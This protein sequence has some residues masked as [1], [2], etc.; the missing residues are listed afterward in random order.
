MAGLSYF[1]TARTHSSSEKELRNQ[2]RVI[3]TI[4]ACKKFTEKERRKIQKN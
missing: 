3:H 1:K 2:Y 4:L